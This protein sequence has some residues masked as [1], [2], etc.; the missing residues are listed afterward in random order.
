MTHEQDPLDRLEG[1]E[2]FGS[3][4]L[5]NRLI[6][7]YD[8]LDR[9]AHIVSDTQSH[10]DME[11]IIIEHE[12][13]DTDEQWQYGFSRTPDGKVTSTHREKTSFRGTCRSCSLSEDQ[14]EEAS[15]T[16]TVILNEDGGVVGAG[17]TD[18]DTYDRNQEMMLIIFDVHDAIELITGD[19]AMVTITDN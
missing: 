16:S 18:S 11:L 13:D 1:D 4:T 6:A 3:E 9:M 10:S 8:E 15:V 12:K 17:A 2:S 14:P 7:S 5:R 19:H